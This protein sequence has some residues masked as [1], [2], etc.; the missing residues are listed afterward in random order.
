MHKILKYSVIAFIF[1]FFSGLTAS[2]YILRTRFPINYLHIIEHYAA[3]HE[4]DPVLIAAII[5]VESGFNPN[6]VS[7]AG[8]SGL[9]QLMPS[10]A[11]WAAEQI[12][13]ENFNCEMIFHPYININLGT[14][15]IRRLMDN[16]KDFN[17]ALAAYN[18]GSGNVARWLDDP[19]FSSDGLTLDYIPFGETRRYVSR[20]Q[21]NL[22]IYR[23]R[24][25]LFGGSNAY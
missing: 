24:L 16:H 8:A 3:V 22:W 25:N 17:V 4:V 20:I 18:A 21:T 2:A 19:K 23:I 5:N 6:A 7:P 12:G 9:M 15:Y 10:T 14:W 1:V 11:R 13:M